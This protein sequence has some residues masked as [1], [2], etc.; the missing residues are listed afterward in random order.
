[1]SW[2][3][4]AL[5]TLCSIKTGKKD[6]NEGSPNGEYPFFTCA[7][8][9]TYSDF[10]SFDCE[11]ILIAGN[12]A[13]GQTSYYNGKFEAYQ[14][15][16]VLCNFVNV[17]PKY[18]LYVLN[19]NLIQELSNKVLGNT[20]PY[21]K[22]GML[23]DFQVPLPS[24]ATQQKIVEKLDAIF[25][26]IDRATVATEANVKNAE[27]LFQRYLKKIFEE[28]SDWRKATIGEVLSLIRNGIN[29]EQNKTPIG[30]KIT[31]IETIAKKQFDF[32]RVGFAILN[33]SEKERSRLIAGDILFSHINS[34]IHV[35]KTAIYEA[36]EEIFHGINLLLMRTNKDVNPFFFNY[37]LNHLYATGYWERNCK[38]SVN[39]ASV[40]Q[41]DISKVAFS[42]PQTS[43]QERLVARFDAISLELRKSSKLYANKLIE[44]STLKQSILKQAFNGEL[45]KE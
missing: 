25:A 10:Y 1:V 43:I 5:G 6:V 24:L 22:K 19:G 34:P 37:F 21:I 29:C 13:V 12:G 28:N 4:V 20:I 3:S 35:G 14:R 42:Y 41:K 38:K 15:T 40:N 30:N 16:Y 27:A 8:K 9:H 11:A 23:T 18:L 17:L 7:S 45:V 36:E 31:R 33:E 39:Q 44:L 26:E 2:K 32:G